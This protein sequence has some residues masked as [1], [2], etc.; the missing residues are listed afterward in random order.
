MQ[1]E[2]GYSSSWKLI[3]VDPLSWADG[4]VLGHVT[5]ASATKSIDSDAPSVDSGNF[6]L[7]AP[8]PEVGS[9]VRLIMDARADGILSRVPI[10]TGRVAP[11]SCTRMGALRLKS[12]VTIESVLKPAEDEQM[13]EGWYAPQG[14]D[15]A[16][17]AR[18]LLRGCIDAPIEI[19]TGDRPILKENVVAANESVLAIVWALLGDTWELIT[20]GRGRVILRPRPQAPVATVTDAMLTTKLTETTSDDILTLNYTREWSDAIVIGDA[21]RIAGDSSVWRIVSQNITC[22][23]GATVAETVKEL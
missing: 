1:Y 19:A 11:S 8:A 20:D 4:D 6:S 18:Q 14:A 9:Y 17:I 7:S 16:A 3:A 13:D 10:I 12:D 22:G 15:G 5:E 21:V 23:C 2:Y